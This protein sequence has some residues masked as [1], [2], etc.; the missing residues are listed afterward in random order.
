MG[1]LV[2]GLILGLGKPDAAASQAGPP[3]PATVAPF[4]EGTVL[5]RFHVGTSMADAD[6]VVRRAG[7]NRVRALRSGPSVLRVPAGREREVSDSLRR[8]RQVAYA[9]PN[10]IWRATVD[11]SDTSY[12]QLWGLKNTGQVVNGASGTSDADIDANDAWDVTTGSAAVVVGVVDTGV[13][14][15]H[16]DLAGNMWTKPQGVTIGSFACATG[17]RGY[18]AVNNT[19]DPLDDH[20]HGSHVA[21]TIGARG[22]N[23]FGVVGVNWS[24]SIMGLKFLNSSGSG[25]TADAIETFDYAIKAK[26]AGVNVRVLSNSWGGG[27]YSQA[28]K[29]K[30]DEAGANDILV[31]AAAG[32][33][34]AFG[35]GYS[36]DSAPFYPCS[37]TSTN[38]ICVAATTQTDAKASFSNYGATSVDLGAPGTNILSTIRGAGYSYYNGTSMATPHVSGA[39]ALVLASCSRTASQLKAAILNNVDSVSSMAGRTVS[40]GRLNVNR[41]VRSGCGVGGGGDV[42]PPTVTINQ[43]VGQA[44]PSSASPVNFTVTFSEPVTGFTTGDVTLAGTAGATTATVTGS[45]ATYNVAVTGM[46]SSGSVVASIPAAVVQDLAGYGNTASASTDNVV[47]YQARPSPSCSA[48]VTSSTDTSPSGGGTVT[49]NWT[50]SAAVTQVRVQRQ[51]SDGT[52]STRATT[53]S[54][55][56]TGSDSSLDPFWRLVPQCGGVDYPGT[57]FDPPYP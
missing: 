55:T 3:E 21:G 15:N 43:A 34:N 41:A 14:Y 11:P 27:G 26:Q 7:A 56:F 23:T 13:D 49:I 5:V 32:N 57:P 47:T 18:N 50:K 17:T 48:S 54:T 44:D 33:G 31:V 30:I 25:T 4:E 38:L 6:D 42:T 37:Y 1:A 24:A 45:G 28:L 46:I 29:D 52:W 20:N 40:G 53:T 51:R 2:L 8:D 9:E 39:A 36:V 16:P 10:Y 12:A 19:C 22:N 35:V